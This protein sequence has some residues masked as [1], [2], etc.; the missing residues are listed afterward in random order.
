MRLR[1]ITAIALAAGSIA[2]SVAIAPNASAALD[3]LTLTLTDQ[4]NGA[5]TVTLDC[6]PTGGTHP[7]AD[8]ACSDLI[9]AN[10]QI[11]QIPPEWG[12]VCPTYYDPTTASA[13]GYW[14]GRSV[15]YQ[16][17]FE[18]PCSANVA[19]GGHVFHF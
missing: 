2:A 4:Y 11:S 5:K 7:D 16:N 17:D 9:A 18:N 1:L 12:G 8:A 3:S 14:R 10:G 13:S 19:T 15:S 6:E